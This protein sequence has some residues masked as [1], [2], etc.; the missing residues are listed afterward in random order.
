MRRGTGG[1]GVDMGLSFRPATPLWFGV[2]RMSSRTSERF[3]DEVFFSC[4][5]PWL[6]WDVFGRKVEMSAGAKRGRVSILT[7]RPAST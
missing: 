5:T 2:F 7:D 3:C 4:F 6:D 1:R